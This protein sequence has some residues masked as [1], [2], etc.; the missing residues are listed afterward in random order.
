MFDNSV[1]RFPKGINNSRDTGI[2]SDMPVGSFVGYHTYVDD[3]D[4]FVAANYTITKTQVGA[5]TA[6]A[7][8]DGG[9]LLI[10]NTTASSDQ[11]QLTRC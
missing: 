5:T 7:N 3:F 9:L 1:T 6:L 10:T 2:F 11:V 4:Y 8:G